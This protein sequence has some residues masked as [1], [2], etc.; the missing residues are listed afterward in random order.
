MY[1]DVHTKTV[2]DGVSLDI[3]YES[4]YTGMWVQMC[5]WIYIR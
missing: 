1:V 3:I 4:V 5:V 2:L